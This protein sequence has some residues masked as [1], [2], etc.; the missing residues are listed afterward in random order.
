M[1]VENGCKE[2]ISHHM[3]KLQCC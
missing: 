2:V 1:L 3:L